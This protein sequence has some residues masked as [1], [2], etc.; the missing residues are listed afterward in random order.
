MK[1][2]IVS[3]MIGDMSIEKGSPGNRG[4]FFDP[5]NINM[6]EENYVNSERA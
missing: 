6:R 2:C 1:I 3:E 4:A 5:R